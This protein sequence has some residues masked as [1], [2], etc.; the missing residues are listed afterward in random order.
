MSDTYHDIQSLL[1]LIHS[2]KKY[3]KEG[4]SVLGNNKYV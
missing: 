3:E 4:Q 2:A 1:E